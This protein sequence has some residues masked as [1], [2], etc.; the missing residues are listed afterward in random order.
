MGAMGAAVL[1][2]MAAAVVSVHAAENVPY[3][4]TN[5]TSINVCTSEYTPMVYCEG[6]DPS[7]YSGYEIELF[8][9][10]QLILGWTDAML[11]WSCL[12]R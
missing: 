4:P 12:V 11:N 8:R 1:V 7:G 3:W 5:K 10:V 9:K 6:R 2:L